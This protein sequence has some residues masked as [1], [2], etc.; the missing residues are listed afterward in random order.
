MAA[1]GAL[2][3]VTS[4][5]VITENKDGLGPAVVLPVRDVGR[6]ILP[7][8]YCQLF[9]ATRILFDHGAIGGFW[10]RWTHGSDQYSDYKSVRPCLEPKASRLQTLRT[11]FNEPGAIPLKT[12]KVDCLH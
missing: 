8:N 11:P 9:L 1:S 10:A 7:A 2:V 6:S 5:S 4:Q 3:P 12:L